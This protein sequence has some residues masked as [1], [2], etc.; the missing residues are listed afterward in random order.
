MQNDNHIKIERF[1]AKVF[2]KSLQLNQIIFCE[3]KS[4]LMTKL[5][6]NS[7]PQN[8]KND[9]HNKMTTLHRSRSKRLTSCDLKIEN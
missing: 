9:N 6:K 1:L 2:V 8:C 5:Q 3:I 7:I 4:I